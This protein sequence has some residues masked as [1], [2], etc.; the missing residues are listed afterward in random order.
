[1]VLPVPRNYETEA[2]S[3]TSTNQTRAAAALAPEDSDH[4]LNTGK[5]T[6]VTPIASAL[7]VPRFLLQVERGLQLEVPFRDLGICGHDNFDMDSD[8][9]AGT[10]TDSGSLPVSR[11]YGHCRTDPEGRVRRHWHFLNFKT[12]VMTRMHCQ[13]SVITDL[14]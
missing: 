1:M 5:N 3:P 10:C 14:T 6:E 12:K 2:E 4:V 13:W 7:P 8:L 11:I 9:S